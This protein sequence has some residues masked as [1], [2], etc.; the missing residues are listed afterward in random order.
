MATISAGVPKA[1]IHNQCGIVLEGKKTAL[2]HGNH[3]AG[4]LGLQ[5]TTCGW[6]MW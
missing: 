1:I 3:K 4:D 5:F 2:I 6:M